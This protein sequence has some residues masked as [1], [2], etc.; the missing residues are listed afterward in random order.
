MMKKFFR[1]I[2]NIRF[3]SR[4]YFIMGTLIVIFIAG[5]IFPVLYRIGNIILLSWILFLM[6]DSFLLFRHSL[7]LTAYR[8]SAYSKLSNGDENYFRV[9]VQNLTE[10]PWQITFLE[11]FPEQF[12]I[13]D[14]VWFFELPSRS[15]H[16]IEYTLRPVRRGEY[17]FGNLNFLIQRKY[18]VIQRYFF[19][20]AEKMMPCYPS[21]IR[22]RQFEFLAIHNRLHEA[23]IK[24]IRKVGRSTEFEQIKEYVQGDDIRTINWKATARMS[25]LMVNHYVEE[26]SQPVY[27]LIDMGRTMFMPF[28]GMSL[29]DYAINT[30]LIFSHIAWIKSDKPGLLGFEKNISFFLPASN[31]SI[32]LHRIQEHL[33]NASTHF[34][35]SSFLRLYKHIRKHIHQR[36]LLFLFTNMEYYLTLERKIKYLQRINRFH[37]LVVIIFKNT[38]L[39]QLIEHKP[40]NVFD[41]YKK[42]IAIQFENQ[43]KKI[44]YELARNGI[45]SIYTEPEHLT[46]QVINKYL[47][48]KNKNLL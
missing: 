24:R 30:S 25:R 5:F 2:W 6:Y 16:E 12:Q 1:N 21:F 36:S 18:G 32:Q 29:L 33:Y 26:K 8:Q 27:C 48:I 43:K 28:N 46:V 23:G 44:Q 14:K 35:E 17:Y 34:E 11:D 47:E 20:A 39:R 10:I 31:Q 22:L 42:A 9:Y 15:Y 38:E 4:F 41:I 13:R 3:S 37:C 19:V 7:P 45:L 40:E